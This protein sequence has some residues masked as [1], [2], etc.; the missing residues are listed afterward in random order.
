MAGIVIYSRVECH[1]CDEAKA[2]IE[3]IAA[4]RGIPIEVVDVDTSQ[5]LKDLYGL[6]VPV[7]FVNG[8]KAFK[9]R[10]DTRRLEELLDR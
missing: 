10:V 9:Y 1:L 2:A 7:V 6:E 5:E 8:R 4:R 3:P